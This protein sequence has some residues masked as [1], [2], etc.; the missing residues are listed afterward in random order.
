MKSEI[1]SNNF[2]IMNDTFILFGRRPDR[3]LVDKS[4]K[5]VG[6][7]VLK[8]PYLTPIIN[9][10]NIFDKLSVKSQLKK[11]FN[12]NMIN[13]GK[14]IDYSEDAYLEASDPD[15]YESCISHEFYSKLKYCWN[16][17]V[18]VNNIND[19]NNIPNE[20]LLQS[21]EFKEFKNFYDNDFRMNVGSLSSQKTVTESDFDLDTGYND[22][23]KKLN[24][25]HL[26]MS[27]SSGVLFENNEKMNNSSL[28]ISHATAKSTFG[29]SKT[30]ISTK[31]W[32]PHEINYQRQVQRRGGEL[33]IL[34]AANNKGRMKAPWRKT[35]FERLEED[36][37]QVS[38]NCEILGMNLEDITSKALITAEIININKNG[39]EEMKSTDP[40][41]KEEEVE[42]DKHNVRTCIDSEADSMRDIQVVYLT[43]KST[44]A[45]I[46]N[47]KEAK[48]L[49]ER[50][51]CF[52]SYQYEHFK[53]ITGSL[54]DIEK[55]RKLHKLPPGQA[56][57]DDEKLSMSLEDIMIQR[58][59]R[60]CRIKFGRAI[61]K[62]IIKKRQEASTRIQMWYRRRKMNQLSY[63]RAIQL[64][65]A[66]ILQVLKHILISS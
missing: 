23:Q 42:V 20:I 7:K 11:K 29:E 31:L 2:H 56:I 33:Y 12:N 26:S 21:N 60:R 66:L 34:T 51:K 61:R 55:L 54:T 65:L 10:P 27:E 8:S 17:L 44:Y 46:M 62:A 3:I 25:F 47:M 52:L 1:L 43:E 22:F 5:N 30:L 37:K 63:F 59:Q 49:E 64:K 57:D 38:V 28:R 19:F 39:A 53:M 14:D 4:N 50:R 35:R 6:S 58:I 32:T 13:I 15:P 48:I 36:V 45:S 18:K 40:S 24:S 16:I 9:D 41:G